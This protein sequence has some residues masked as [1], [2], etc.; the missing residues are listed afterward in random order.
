MNTDLIY[1]DHAAATPIDKRVVAAMQPY[2]SDLFF[3]PS[4]PYRP[5]LD[6]R[7]DYESAKDT[8]AHALGTKGDELVMTAGATESINLAFA[9]M[10]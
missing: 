10:T 7:R 4:S 3:N 5:A 8:I 2:F 6:V 1:L 9:S